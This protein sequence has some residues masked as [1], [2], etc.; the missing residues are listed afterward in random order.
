MQLCCE[1]MSFR[2]MFKFCIT[3][4]CISLVQAGSC[5]KR[6]FDFRQWLG[7]AK[8]SDKGPWQVPS[9]IGWTSHSLFSLSSPSPSS[10]RDCFSFS[11]LS[12]KLLSSLSDSLAVRS[13][14][15]SLNFPYLTHNLPVS[16]TLQ[17]LSL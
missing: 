7:K 16:I 10:G 2:E 14:L 9:S 5:L 1:K 12:P 3:S 4:P 15:L 8:A 17:P 13:V 6:L 11:L